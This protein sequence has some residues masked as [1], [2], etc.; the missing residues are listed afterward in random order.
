MFLG[1]SVLGFV[2]YFVVLAVRYVVVVDPRRGLFLVPKSAVVAARA[3]EG[4]KESEERAEDGEEGEW[5]EAGGE[6]EG[7]EEEGDVPEEAEP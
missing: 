6:E 1:G 3:R 5:R 4:E 2:G 7:E